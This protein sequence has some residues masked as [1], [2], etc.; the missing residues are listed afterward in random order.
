MMLTGIGAPLG[1]VLY[2]V[3]TAASAISSA[4]LML[5][6]L[7]GGGGSAPVIPEAPKF[8]AGKYFDSIRR[9]SYAY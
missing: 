2:G 1:A 9:S 4:G 6:G 3:G 5:E 8:N 7:F